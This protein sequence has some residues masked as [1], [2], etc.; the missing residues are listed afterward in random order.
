MEVEVNVS[1]GSTFKEEGRLAADKASGDG[2]GA[3]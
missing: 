2:D 3:S 1:K